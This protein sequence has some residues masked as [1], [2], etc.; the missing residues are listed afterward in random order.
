MANASDMVMQEVH[1]LHA[2][3]VVLSNRFSSG[4]SFF[5]RHYLCAEI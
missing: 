2:D 5:C 1:M 3:A 4:M